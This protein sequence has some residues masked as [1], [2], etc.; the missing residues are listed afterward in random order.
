M[1]NNKKNIDKTTKIIHWT[2]R[3]LGSIS[4]A[5]WVLALTL[6]TI[7]ESRLGVEPTPE[8]KLEGTILGCLVAVV[9]IGVIIAWFREGIGG[10]IVVIGGIVLSI[11][12]YITAGHN[13]VLAMASSGI[14]FLIA[15]IL[16]LIYWRR[17]RKLK[18]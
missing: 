10:L 4:G 6:S 16:F 1:V 3:I 12:A 5:F 15:G 8:A 13:K 17:T 7:M 11:F 9:V 18:S 2:A 14:P